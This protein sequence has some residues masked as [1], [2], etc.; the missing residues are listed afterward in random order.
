MHC[1][2]EPAELMLCPT[3]DTRGSAKKPPGLVIRGV[4]LRPLLRS[5]AH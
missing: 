1:V 5:H 2:P 3:P 4:F